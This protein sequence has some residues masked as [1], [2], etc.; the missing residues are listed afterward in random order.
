MRNTNWLFKLAVVL[1]C[2]AILLGSAVG[3]DGFYVIATGFRLPFVG[4]GNYE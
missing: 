2:G 3:D 4:V 1:L